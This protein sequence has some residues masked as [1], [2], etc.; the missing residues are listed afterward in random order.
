MILMICT[1]SKKVIFV[2][3][4]WLN[5]V[6]NWIANVTSDSGTIKMSNTLDPSPGHSCSFDVDE[7]VLFERMKP[8]FERDFISRENFMQALAES[9]DGVSLV[10]NGGRIGI[11]EP[12]ISSKVNEYSS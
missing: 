8:L 11:S 2:P 1:F 10:D 3:R 4:S 6:A 5:A 9:V 7:E 12:W